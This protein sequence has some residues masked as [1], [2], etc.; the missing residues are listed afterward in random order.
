[1]CCECVTGVPQVS[2]ARRRPVSHVSWT[3]R[4]KLPFCR[5]SAACISIRCAAVRVP[6]RPVRNTHRRTSSHLAPA[7]R[8]VR[9]RGEKRPQPDACGIG[10]CVRV[11]GE[12]RPRPD[13]C[14]TGG[15]HCMRSTWN[16]ALGTHTHGTRC[17]R[18]SR[19]RN[20]V[21]LALGT[22]TYGTQCMHSSRAR[23]S[24]PLARGTQF[25]SREELT[26]MELS[27]CVPLARGVPRPA[28][29]C[30][31][32][33]VAR[34]T[35]GTHCMRACAAPLPYEV[36]RGRVRSGQMLCLLWSNAV[37][38]GPMLC[39]QRSNAVFA[40][41]KG[42]V[43]SGQMLCFLWSIAVCSG[44]MWRRCGSRRRSGG[45][46]PSRSCR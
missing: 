9:V 7:R 45:T 44:R 40:V 8:C 22:H 24:V 30:G 33:P 11:R 3:K 12:K 31:H 5:Y 25:L 26:H 20:S 43:R 18:S 46:R 10:T 16:T 42:R 13:A 2:G 1:V 23:T 41:V 28:A 38:S 32:P 34:E 15:T 19:A 27:V 17:M 36:A 37:C 29:R 39:A 21:P 14:G 35:R 6:A 4:R